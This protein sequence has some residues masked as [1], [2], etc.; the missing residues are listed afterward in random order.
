[1]STRNVIVTGAAG[2]M[3][4]AVLQE[5]AP[6]DVNVVAVDMQVDSVRRAIEAAGPTQGEFVAVGADVTDSAAV[7]EFIDD[8]A[9]RLGGLDGLFMVAGA[10]GELK[11]MIEATVENFDFVMA[12]NARS[13]FLG[14]KHALPHLISRGGGTIVST[15]SLLSVKGGE[16]LGPYGASKHAVVGLTKSLAVEEAIH[17]VRAN[18]VCP[19][20]MDTRMIQQLFPAISDDPAEALDQLVRNIP[21]KRLAQPTELAQTGVWLLLDAPT[22]LNGQVLMV[23]GGSS[24][25]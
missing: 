5:L 19:G 13:V 17:G 21:D 1:M 18:V 12:A 3:G 2:G 8:A 7:Q 14:M 9:A 20:P 10:E 4:S 6:R 22:H 24:A 11:P 15:G 16:A 23:D 25:R